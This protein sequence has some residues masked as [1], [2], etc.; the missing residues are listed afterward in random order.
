MSDSSLNHIDNSACMENVDVTH[1][2]TQAE[3]KVEALEKRLNFLEQ[4]LK[5]TLELVVKKEQTL[6]ITV[7]SMLARVFETMHVGLNQSLKTMHAQ[8]VLKDSPFTIEPV[9]SPDE[10]NDQTILITKTKT[11]YDFASHLTPEVIA[12]NNTELFHVFLDANPDFF[13]DK[14]TILANVYAEASK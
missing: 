8:I 2:L 12:N 3:L 4:S 9:S 1:D 5:N 7:T 11:G 10:I 14:D 13:R 6:E